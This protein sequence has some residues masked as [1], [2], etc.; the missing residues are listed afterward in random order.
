M[1]FLWVSQFGV[2]GMIYI[3][4]KNGT[5]EDATRSVTR[6][7][8]AVW[9]D[10]VNMLLWFA[11]AVGRIVWCCIVGRVTRRTD[12]GDLAKEAR[13]AFV[14]HRPSLLCEADEEFSKDNS[15]TFDGGSMEDT[16]KGDDQS[17]QS[18]LENMDS[19]SMHSEGKE[20]LKE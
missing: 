14:H 19:E 7:K 12:R 15:Q 18:N 5:N 2:F 8:V 20:G 9:M 16:L 13:D 1:F 4:G 3:G 11:T 10:F 17:M 6:M